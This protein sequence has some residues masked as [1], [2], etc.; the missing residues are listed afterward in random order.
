MNI[1]RI[2]TGIDGTVIMAQKTNVTVKNVTEDHGT[3]RNLTKPNQ[4][5]APVNTKCLKIS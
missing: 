3:K 4:T 2:G 5:E 1:G